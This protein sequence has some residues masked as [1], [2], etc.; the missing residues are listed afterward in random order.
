M[1]R[2]GSPTASPIDIASLLAE[3]DVSG[4]SAAAFA[5]SRGVAT[6]RIYHALNRR[7]GKSRAGS[8]AAKRPALLPVRVVPEAGAVRA[9]PVLV[10][11][12]AGGHR[13]RIGADF[14]AVLLRRVL[15][16]LARC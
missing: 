14:D 9:E 13:L 16:A 12:L 1:N 4:L 15:E 11:E 3:F 2:T 6:W 8:A 10:L 7:S 5:R